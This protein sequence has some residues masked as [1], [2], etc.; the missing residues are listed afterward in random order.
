MKYI[1]E[2]SIIE[3]WK[4]LVTAGE[5]H[6][7]SL[8]KFF[9]ILEILRHID[10]ASKSQITP[11]IEYRLTTGHLSTTL[12]NLYYFG[13]NE[14]EFNSDE[15]MH[16]VFPQL[17]Q[18]NILEIFLKNNPLSIVEVA[19]VCLQG[20]S[21]DNNDTSDQVI[22]RFKSLYH[23]AN[24]EEILFS[25]DKKK[26]E[27]S[28]TSI[29]RKNIFNSLKRFFN[30]TENDKFSIAF[31]KKLILANPGELT[32][33]PL[34]Q[35]LY[36]AQENLKCILITNFNIKDFY[37]IQPTVRHDVLLKDDTMPRNKIIYGAPGTGKSFEL[38]NQ[39]A[40]NGFEP[41]NTFRI[42]FHPNF[43]YQQFVGTYKPTSIYKHVGKEIELFESDRVT[44]LQDP[45]NKEPLIDYSFVAGPFLKLLIKALK[46]KNQNFLLIIEEINR[47]PVSAVFGDVFQ[48]LDRK[49]NGESEYEIEFNAD[50][51][52][53][54]KSQDIDDIKIKLPRNLFIWATMNSADQGVM[55]MDSAFKRRWA[56]EYLPLNQKEKEVATRD[57]IFQKK[58]VNWNFFRER[59]NKKLKSLDVAEDKLLGP[60]FLNSAELEDPSSIKN[61]LLLYLRE[62]VVRHN[63]E[64]LFSQKTFS[65][66]VKAYD[67]DKE[68]FNGINFLVEQPVND[69]AGN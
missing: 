62:D 45:N 16:V 29:K 48:L 66:I 41:E 50:V 63:A 69:P 39:A 46:N 19:S 4:N 35:V 59:L 26:I 55:P 36:A 32:R 30:S 60:F 27:F 3:S 38:R 7:I 34:I 12:Q 18:K 33:G 57:I 14:R 67:D 6:R 15:I 52:N 23:I 25:S 28:P 2:A 42:T 51:S 47:A 40:A 11:N 20:V 49:G 24:E 37:N 22:E 58:K 53:F 10:I 5:T 31:E 56:F 64:N 44:K 68:I 61:K 17:W 13:D 21:F 43:S 9:G 1:S 54:L 65:D 8:N